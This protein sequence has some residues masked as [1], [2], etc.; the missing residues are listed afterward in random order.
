[1][2]RTVAGVLLL[3]ILLAGG[4]GSA[5]G[6]SRQSETLAAQM[7]AATQLALSGDLQEARSLAAAA[8]NRW[9]S[10]YPIHAVFTDHGPLDTIGLGF[11]RLELY[12]QAEDWT[13]F[14]LA[15]T[16]LAE[17]LRDLGETQGTQWWNLL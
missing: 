8:R 1:M 7:D 9:E 12:A 14:A 15:C 13:G 16:E 5:A 4:I 11:S 3:L 6:L 17:Q 2:N 10:V